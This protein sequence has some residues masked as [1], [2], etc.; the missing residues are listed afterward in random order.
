LRGLSERA[1]TRLRGRGIRLP[2]APTAP[3]TTTCGDVTPFYSGLD[4]DVATLHFSRDTSGPERGW[5]PVVQPARYRG[6]AGTPAISINN[7]PIG[8]RSSMVSEADPLKLVSA[9]LVTFLSRMPLYVFHSRAGV[10]GDIEFASLPSVDATFEGFRVLRRVVPNAIA[11]AT[12]I[13]AGAPGTLL[14]LRSPVVRDIAR[15]AGVVAFEGV[16][17]AGEELSAAVGVRGSLA[18]RAQRGVDVEAYDLLTGDVVRR[19]G[20]APGATV[21][22]DGREAWFIRARASAPTP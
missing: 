19:P 8:P 22:L 1:I 11:T 5:A 10:R 20:V 2:V 4:F 21:V 17:L 12:P 14:E 3:P 16:R 18:L 7:E 9:A 13:A 6:C 15:D